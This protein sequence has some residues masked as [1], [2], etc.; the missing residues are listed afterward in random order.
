MHDIW[1]RMMIQK[2]LRR[3]QMEGKL[4]MGNYP[5]EMSWEC[6]QGK[7][8]DL[9]QPVITLIGWCSL[10]STPNALSQPV[11]SYDRETWQWPAGCVNF[12]R[13]GTWYLHSCDVNDAC[14]TRLVQFS[15]PESSSQY[16][17]VRDTFLLSIVRNRRNL[18]LNSRPAIFR[19]FSEKLRR[20]REVIESTQCRR[21]WATTSTTDTDVSCLCRCADKLGDNTARPRPLLPTKR[22]HYATRFVGVRLS[23][24]SV[25]VAVIV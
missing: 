7:C 14:T 1:S 18:T 13:R 5:G 25:C 9:L 15:S 3:E 12:N 22:Y 21:S 4:S 24:A 2:V 19:L 16:N 10:V 6:V 11:T 23:S 20:S 17:S 8:A